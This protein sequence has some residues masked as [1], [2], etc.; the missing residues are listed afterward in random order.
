M[1]HCLHFSRHTA[2]T[3]SVTQRANTALRELRSESE[4][5]SAY[6]SI[7]QQWDSNANQNDRQTDS[8]VFTEIQSDHII[9]HM[10]LKSG[11][12]RPILAPCM[13]HRESRCGGAFALPAQAA[14]K[15]V[16]LLFF[17]F[18]YK[19]QLYCRVYRPIAVGL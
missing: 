11:R 5:C 6:L 16:P 7:E 15:L 19:R 9:V 3:P 14:S 17:F 13:M 4:E 2:L 1:L 18:Q 8:L 12:Q 10:P